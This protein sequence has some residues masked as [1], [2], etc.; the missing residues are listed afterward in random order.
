VRLYVSNESYPELREIGSRWQ[1]HLT[2]WRAFG[3]AFRD[4]R[5]WIFVA[6]QVVLVVGSWVLAVMLVL[7]GPG[8]MNVRALWVV[9]AMILSGLL[10]V[11]WGGD[12]IRPHLRRVSSLSR[13]ACPACGHLLTSQRRSEGGRSVRCP[14]CGADVPRALFEQPHRIPPEFRALRLPWARS[15]TGA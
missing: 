15:R 9:L 7:E 12:L 13:D 5:F 4:H 8:G 14:E 2:W 10:T 11:T 6:A 3:S 1:R